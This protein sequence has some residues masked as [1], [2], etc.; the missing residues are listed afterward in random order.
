MLVNYLHKITNLIFWQF[1][2]KKFEN[3]GND[4]V[5]YALDSINQEKKIQFILVQEHMCHWV[6][7]ILKF[8]L[9]IIL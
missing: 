1:R 6:W 3:T 9:K 7:I 4:E 8:I 5:K 2:K